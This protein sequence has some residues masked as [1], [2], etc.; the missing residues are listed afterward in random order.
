MTLKLY[1]HPLSPYARKVKIVLYEKGIS[2]ERVFVSPTTGESSP[3]A[4]AWATS[5]PRLEVP[6]LVDGELA[7][8]DS[9]I[10]LDYVEERWPEPAT[11]PPTPE[12]RARVRMLEELC[13]TEL[14]A[15][16]WGIMELLFFRRAEGQLASEMMRVAGEQLG[17][18]WR[19][20]DRELD[21]RGW[22][23]GIRFGRGDAAVYPHVAGSAA[24]G[25]PLSDDVPRLK[26]WAEQC[27]ERESVQR[28][29]E[30]S[31][32]WIR[33]N[34]GAEASGSGMPTVRQYRD[35]RLEWMMKSGGVEIVLKGIENG[36]IRFAEE[37]R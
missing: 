33:D 5:S 21:G 2:F 14:E 11:L 32:A 17:R 35:Y 37:H 27:A 1:E 25:F 6:T 18:L 36:T 22:M 23:N 24:W 13:D 26:A 16:N 9:T 19:R 30:Q 3:E 15:V 10:L 12:E 34:L 4:E 20:L 8:F 28:D 7:I 29:A 31:S